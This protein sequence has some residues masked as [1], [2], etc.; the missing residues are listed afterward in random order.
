MKNL[1]VYGTL[2]RGYPNHRVMPPESIFLDKATLPGFSLV[3]IG[4]KAYPGLVPNDEAMVKG[5]AWM[6]PDFKRTDGLEGYDPKNPK[7]SH[8]LRESVKIKLEDSGEEVWAETYVYNRGSE[9][10]PNVPNGDWRAYAPPK[11]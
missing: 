5:E 7:Y 11:E 10:L 9:G 4:G 6:V 2:M 8:Y 3:A 1:F